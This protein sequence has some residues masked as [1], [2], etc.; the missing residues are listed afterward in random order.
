MGVVDRRSFVRRTAGI[1]GGALIP[2]SVSGLLAG[3]SETDPTG[4][5]APRNSPLLR[6]GRGGGGYGDLTND[7]GA[8]LLPDG[9]KVQAFSAVGDPMSDGTTTPIAHD[10]MA[11]FPWMKNRVRLIRN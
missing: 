8:L 11:V 7:A 5:L 4:A 9:F 10:G 3:C 6:A 1:A 2:L